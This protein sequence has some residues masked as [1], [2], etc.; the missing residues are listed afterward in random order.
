MI[1]L[2]MATQCAFVLGT[3]MVQVTYFI[4]HQPHHVKE[5]YNRFQSVSDP[6][7]KLWGQHLS[8]AEV[9]ALQT[10]AQEHLEVVQNHLAA[11]NATDI[12]FTQGNESSSIKYY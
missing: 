7:S 6:R 10:P 5:L 11:V 1:A 4:K 8:H 2:L 9:V 3:D 12:R